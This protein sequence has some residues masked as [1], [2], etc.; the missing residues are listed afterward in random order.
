MENQLIQQQQ[1]GNHHLENLSPR[2]IEIGQVVFHVNQLTAYPLNDLQISDW[3]KSINE[4]KP[5]LDLALL[6]KVID[7]FKMDELEW[8][9]HKGI[10]NIFR[11]LKKYGQVIQF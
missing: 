4:L 11:E 6:K 2:E 7:K 5:D 1:R 8:D 9:N 10:Q 3:A